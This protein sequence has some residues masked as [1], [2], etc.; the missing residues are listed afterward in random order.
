MA[1]LGRP[2]LII[3]DETTSRLAMAAMVRAAGHS[4][5]LAASAEE[6]LARAA[7]CCPEAVL[8][9]RSMPDSDGLEVLRA[10][11]R[12]PDYA[13]LPILL[14]T[15]CKRPRDLEDGFAAGADDYLIKPVGLAQLIERIASAL[16]LRSLDAASRRRMLSTR[17]NL[18]TTFALQ[19]SRR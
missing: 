3:D 6:G 8:L 5:I 10:L 9:D 14:V 17:A 11:R 12:Q 1:H 4:P 16:Q 7:E 18:L 2:I 15:S 19:R 13:T